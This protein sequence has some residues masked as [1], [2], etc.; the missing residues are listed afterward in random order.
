MRLLGA[1]LCVWLF[2]T[3]CTTET[4]ALASKS[5]Q[6]EMTL[7]KTRADIEELK[8]DIHSHNV[9]L[10]ILDGKIL[11]QGYNIS[12]LQEKSFEEHEEKIR[13]YQSKIQYLENH[14][15]LLEK[16]QQ[17]ILQKIE[18]LESSYDT[19]HKAITQGKE[20]LNELENQFVE[21]EKLEIAELKRDF[22][23][24]LKQASGVMD[25]QE[26]SS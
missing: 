4:T 7:Q 1:S 6:T 25:C 26:K 12:S 22:Q 17:Q 11:N 23:K 9:E 15:A 20:R 24:L 2:F 10:N 5:Y 16:K 8:Q 3:G 14:I 18:Q 13:L 19:A 21:Q